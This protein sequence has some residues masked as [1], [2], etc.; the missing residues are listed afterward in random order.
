MEVFESYE[1]LIQHDDIYLTNLLFGNGFSI[2]FGSRFRYSSLFEDAVE[3]L[4]KHDIELF[5]NIDTTNFELVLRRLHNT[6]ET[7]KV[8][9][10]GYNTIEESYERIKTALIETVRNVHPQPNEISYLDVQRLR[11]TFKVFRKKAFTTNYDLLAYWALNKVRNSDR[12]VADGFGLDVDT[13]TIMY[14]AG[15]GVSE[16]EQPIRLYHLHGS[17]HLYMNKDEIIKITR[18]Y[19][20]ARTTDNPLLQ[21]ITDTYD[22]GYFPLYISEGTWKQKLNKIL[23][24]KYLHYCYSALSRISEALTIYGQ[25]LDVETD[26]HIIDAI[27]KSGVT[28]IAYGIYDIE[29][30]E[31]I[32]RDVTNAFEDSAIEIMYFNSKDF[33][34]SLLSIDS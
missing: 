30:K 17:L 33:F 3:L 15:V 26:K 19:N 9:K 13:Q 8:F 14:G 11:T 24:N 31:R 18:K 32:I 20:P 21:A 25:A 4:Q 10:I 2:N 29:R 6:I 1:A 27:K 5:E 28:K 22:L 23:N 7:N 16:E 12:R 34:E